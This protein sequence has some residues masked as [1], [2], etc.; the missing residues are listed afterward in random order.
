MLYATKH[1]HIKHSVYFLTNWTYMDLHVTR[2][3]TFNLGENIVYS[4]KKIPTQGVSLFLKL[5]KCPK[6]QIPMN[7]KV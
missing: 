3:L 4:V 2:D 6:Y 5:F 1:K 7:N